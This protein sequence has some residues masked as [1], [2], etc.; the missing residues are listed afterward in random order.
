MKTLLAVY[1]WPAGHERYSKVKKFADTFRERFEELKESP[2][3]PV[4]QSVNLTDNVPG[5]WVKFD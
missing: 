5:E 3:H 2:Y 1:N 4:F